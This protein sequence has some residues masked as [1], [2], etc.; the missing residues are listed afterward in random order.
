M[1]YGI[2]SLPLRVR[3]ERREEKGG[4]VGKDRGEMEVM[5]AEENDQGM[6]M[7]EKEGQ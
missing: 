5:D 3:G 7:T 6:K 4:R 2:L 1:R